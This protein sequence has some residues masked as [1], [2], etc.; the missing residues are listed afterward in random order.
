MVTARD[1]MRTINDYAGVHDTLVDIARKMRD[2]HVS[3][4]P[5]CGDEGELAGV[6]TDHAI[7]D[8]IAD[9]GDPSQLRAVDVLGGLTPTVEADASIE[10]ALL[11]MATL[12]VR[13]LPVLEDGRWVGML[14]HDDVARSIGG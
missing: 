10:H 12:R 4:L 11:T 2:L 1:I 9:G 7:V 3:S 8:G 13:K 5:I 14:A 6:V